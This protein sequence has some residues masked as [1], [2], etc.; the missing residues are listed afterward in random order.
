MSLLL[1]R[2]VLY[3]H[4]NAIQTF[5]L[6]IQWLNFQMLIGQRASGGI[7]YFKAMSYTE[8]NDVLDAYINRM[9]SAN[10]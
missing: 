2:L 9:A 3:I 5:L 8:W 7:L 6:R 10:K 4:C 1:V